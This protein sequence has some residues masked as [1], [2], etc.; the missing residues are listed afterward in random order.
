ML[1]LITLLRRFVVYMLYSNDTW[2]FYSYH[3]SFMLT[4]VQL[5][6]IY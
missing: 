2:H 1:N 5:C 6:I 3:S 4:M